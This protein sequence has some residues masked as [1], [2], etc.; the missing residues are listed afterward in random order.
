MKY[1]FSYSEAGKATA[2]IQKV[3]LDLIKARRETGHTEKVLSL[4][5]VYI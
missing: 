5:E 4:T 3:A 2:Y 1:A